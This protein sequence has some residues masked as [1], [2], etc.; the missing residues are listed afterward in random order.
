MPA[1]TPTPIFPLLL[2]PPD[3]AL[4]LSSSLFDS[5]VVESEDA[6]VVGDMVLASRLDGVDCEFVFVTVRTCVTVST[7]SSVFVVVLVSS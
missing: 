2:S 1:P 4:P 5:I 3:P 6:D 7:P